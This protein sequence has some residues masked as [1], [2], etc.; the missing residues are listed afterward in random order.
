MG[1]SAPYTP[2]DG[3]THGATPLDRI[4]NRIA[5]NEAKKE[6]A[7]ARAAKAKKAKEKRRK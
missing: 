6:R 5:H 2:A 7:K 4:F 3:G 1:W